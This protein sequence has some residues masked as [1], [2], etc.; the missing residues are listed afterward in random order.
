MPNMTSTLTW[1]RL[2][3]HTL[4]DDEAMQAKWDT[5]NAV[6]LDLPFLS[7][8]AV[9]TA[10]ELFGSG[11]E[12]LLVGHHSGQIASMLVLVSD[13]ALR[14]RT[15]QPS[16]LPLGAWVAAPTLNLADM[17]RSAMHGPLR[18]CLVLSITQVDPLLAERQEDANDTCHND[19][20]DTAWLDVQG[21]FDDYWAARGKNLRQNLRKQR[22]RLAAE[23]LSTT[24]RVLR[25]P[26][27][28]APALDRYGILESAGWKAGEGTA[29]HAANTQGNFYRRLLEAAARRG[30]ALVTEYLIGERSVA[31]N[32]CLM[33]NGTLVVL[34]TTYDESMPK[35]LSPAFLLREDELRSVF[36]GDEIRR[37][38]YYGR[39]MEWHTKLTEQKRTLYH[40]S[41]YRWPLIKYLAQRRRRLTQSRSIDT[42]ASSDPS[43]AG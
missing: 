14:W 6:R 13:G 40:L 38:E 34:K 7:A 20:I 4:L 43:A 18:N 3:A 19:Y 28:I 24:M 23:G 2:P 15:F 9:T 25:Q 5:L 10:L 17:C 31:M 29:I 30:E 33:R 26:Q 22:N 32:L 8:A 16:Q 21:S 1:R 41:T 35:S 27:D 37:I 36:A 42:A 11:Q 39:V 12:L